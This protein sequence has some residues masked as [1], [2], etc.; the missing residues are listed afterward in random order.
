MFG[1]HGPVR[2]RRR[3]AVAGFAPPV[4]PQPGGAE[5]VLS[6]NTFRFLVFYFKSTNLFLSCTCKT[7]SFSS[8]FF[9]ISSLVEVEASSRQAVFLM[10]SSAEVLRLRFLFFN[11]PLFKSYLNSFFFFLFCVGHLKILTWIWNTSG[12][13]FLCPPPSCPVFVG[14]LVASVHVLNAPVH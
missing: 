8:S 4:A 6:S 2:P 11:F 1:C 9:K 7:R 3:L 10:L 12:S 13:G 14:A 5:L